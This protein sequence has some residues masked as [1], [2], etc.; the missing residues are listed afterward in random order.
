M[1]LCCSV[2]WDCFKNAFAFSDRLIQ[3]CARIWVQIPSPKQSQRA[4]RRDTDPV[5]CGNKKL[6]KYAHALPGKVSF[7]GGPRKRR[8]S[9][10]CDT[11]SWPKAAFSKRKNPYLTQ[12]HQL[13]FLG[14]EKCKIRSE[15]HLLHAKE[16]LVSHLHSEIYQ[17]KKYHM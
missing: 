2:P 5:P 13:Y 15:K 3:S 12:T 1:A 14:I 6:E 11:K 7:L 10:P 9:S 17:I 16:S 8:N 4:I